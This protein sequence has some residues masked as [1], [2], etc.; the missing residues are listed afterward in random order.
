MKMRRRD[1]RKSEK[2]KSELKKKKNE[3]KNLFVSLAKLLSLLLL[4]CRK[5][6]KR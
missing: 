3:E 4:V 5:E 6:K 1:L 2:E